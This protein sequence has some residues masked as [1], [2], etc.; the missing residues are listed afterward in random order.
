MQKICEEVIKKVSDELLF[1]LHNAI[2]KYTY[3]SH[4][5]NKYYYD[6][7]RKPTYEFL[8]AFQ[9]TN[10]ESDLTQVTRSIFYNWQSMRADPD[11]WLHGSNIKGW[12]PDARE[13][14][15]DF[16][17]KSGL[18]SSLPISV[19]HEPFWSN[20]LDEWTENGK[21]FQLFDREF[22]RYGIRRY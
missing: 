4:G 22:R 20:F 8:N 13:Q 9:L 19:N 6:G 1:R 21:V 10:M 16:L 18:S 14:L 15:A 12:Y 2:Q 5:P 7:S 17:N 11:T 3:R